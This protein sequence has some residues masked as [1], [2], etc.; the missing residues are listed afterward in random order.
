MNSDGTFLLALRGFPAK[1]QPI[2]QRLA[3]CCAG[4]S[5]VAAEQ[6][7]RD[8]IEHTHYNQPRI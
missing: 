3:D 8:E 2:V 5:A 1:R 7:R 6:V 4:A